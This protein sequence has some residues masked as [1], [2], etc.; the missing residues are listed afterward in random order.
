[1][2][3]D[4]SVGVIL[5]EIK[6]ELKHF[7]STRVLILRA[8]ISEKARIWKRSVPLLAI[9]A[10]CLLGSWLAFT[11][12]LI[13][14]VAA[15]FMPA[16]YAWLWGGLI[17]GGAYLLFAAVVGWAGMLGIRRT[18]LAPN[19]TVS[20]LKEDKLWIDNERRAA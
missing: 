13:A 8:E 12:A 16:A 1:M 14:V 4:K 11:F 3:E 10:L 7:L 9:A 2:I 20:V 19:R 6:E 17:V 15:A 5:S 18:G